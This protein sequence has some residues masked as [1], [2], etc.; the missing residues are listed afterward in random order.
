MRFDIWQ[1]GQVE[2]RDVDCPACGVRAG[3]VCFTCRG[4]RSKRYH[5]ERLRAAGLADRVLRW[6]WAN[7]LDAARARL[8][9]VLEARGTARRGV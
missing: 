7:R 8:L 1:Q 6:P 3:R 2:P 9:R 4:R 5:S